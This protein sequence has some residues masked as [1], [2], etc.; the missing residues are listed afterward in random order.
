M[1]VRDGVEITRR[2]FLARA[3]VAGLVAG[4]PLSLPFPRLPLS[5]L[6]QAAKTPLLRIAYLS[7]PGSGSA[8][9]AAA[10][11]VDLARD[12]AGRAAQLL[13][14][15][16]VE[17]VH[18]S[19]SITDAAGV[20]QRLAADGVSVLVVTGNAELT[21]VIGREAQARG[22]IL[23]NAGSSDDRLRAACRRG[24][25]HLQASTAMYLDAMVAGLPRET[26]TRWQIVASDGAV[27]ARAR[28]TIESSGRSVVDSGAEVICVLM[29][30]REPSMQELR[31]SSPTARVVGVPVEAM[32]Q[33]PAATIPVI[34]PVLWHSRLT[35]FGG[36]QL[37]Q[38]FERRYNAPLSSAAW[39]GWMAVKIAWESSLGAAGDDL[40]LA[41]RLT[42]ERARFDGHKGAP[43]TFRK[44]DHQLRQPIYLVRADWNGLTPLAEVPGLEGGGGGE[45]DESFRALLDQVGDAQAE[46]SCETA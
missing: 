4:L 32:D 40:P 30:G 38:R 11:G 34:W 45:G 36:E 43:L 2:E 44:W 37:N 27:A 31:S 5:W 29:D 39:L 9:V 13:G 22:V 15:G 23:L 10:R 17:V 41:D 16:R 35:R 8:S 21:D 20:V 3:S 26:G 25:F 6:E 12:E 46:A 42:D 7:A 1:P 33:P 19:A 18:E 24:T 28:R 14:R